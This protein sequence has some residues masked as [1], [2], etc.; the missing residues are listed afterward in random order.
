MDVLLYHAILH[1]MSYNGMA[2]LVSK[3]LCIDVH[4]LLGIFFNLDHNSDALVSLI[5]PWPVQMP[6]S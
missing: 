4:N 6:D 3:L 2:A 1:I 5:L